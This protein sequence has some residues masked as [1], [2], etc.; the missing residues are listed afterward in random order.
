MC[1][2]KSEMGTLSLIA[3]S[4][5]GSHLEHFLHLIHSSYSFFIRQARYRQRFPAYICQTST[6]YY[7]GRGKRICGWLEGQTTQ[8]TLGRISCHCHGMKNV[9]H[10]GL[11]QTTT[12]AVQFRTNVSMLRHNYPFTP[13]ISPLF[14]KTAFATLIQNEWKSVEEARNTACGH[15]MAHRK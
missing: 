12:T 6:F 4:E 7:W 11:V 13:S 15:R 9:A 14:A 5:G 3:S 1:L 2:T 10:V 8:S